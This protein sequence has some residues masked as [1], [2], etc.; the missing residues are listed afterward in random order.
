M[1]EEVETIRPQ[2]RAL[3]LEEERTQHLRGLERRGIYRYLGGELGS[4]VGWFQV[5]S[6][7]S[8]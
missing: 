4:K 1:I 6:A 2:P 3:Q 8:C 5:A 7:A